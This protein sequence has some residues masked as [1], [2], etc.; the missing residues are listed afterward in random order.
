VIR[1]RFYS[2]QAGRPGVFTPGPAEAVWFAD[3][4]YG[5]PVTCAAA[6]PATCQDGKLTPVY[7]VASS[8]E[9]A[10]LRAP[11]AIDGNFATRWSSAF[12]DPQ[13][14]YV[15]LGAPRF[16]SRVVLNW[17]TAASARYEIQVSDDALGW[18]SVFSEPAG[19]GFTDDIGGLNV[20]ARFVRVFSTAR[21]TRWGNSLWEIQ[22]Y[23][24]D[25]PDCQ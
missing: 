14:I 6:E 3:V 4:I 1:V 15:D 17:E 22:L 18:T 16:V 9:S 19:N 5:Q 8:Q 21:T 11:R 12:S 20:A 24:D 25:D 2:Y 13:W 23:G 10:A 7:A